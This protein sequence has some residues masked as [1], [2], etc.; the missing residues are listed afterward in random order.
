MHF[1]SKLF[2]TISKRVNSSHHLLPCSLQLAKKSHYTTTAVV[3]RK[4]TSSK[5][6]NFDILGTWDSC[7]ELPLELEASINFGKPIPK[8]LVEAIGSHTMQGRR[9][10]NEDRF[11][12]KELKP[13]LLYFA[14]FDGHGGAV[15][16]L[17]I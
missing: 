1:S 5:L 11:I 10:Y 8:I 4:S 3:G 2:S 16:D 7:K 15:Y 6:T 17:L 12:I 9:P 13:N 14:V